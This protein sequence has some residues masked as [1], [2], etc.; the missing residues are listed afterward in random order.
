M[1][2][3]MLFVSLNDNSLLESII[4]ADKRKRNMTETSLSGMM[5]NQNQMTARHRIFWQKQN[6]LLRSTN[7]F[8]AM[9]LPE[10]RAISRLLC[11][12]QFV[13]E[14]ILRSQVMND[15][16]NFTTKDKNIES[17]LL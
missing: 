12:F 4:Q 11:K 7:L 8:K 2:S 9:C 10:I 17:R 5:N 3:S 14:D 13:N 15:L 1:E 6:L 16:R